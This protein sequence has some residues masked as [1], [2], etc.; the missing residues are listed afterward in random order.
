[1]IS[2]I[3]AAYSP[4]AICMSTPPKNQTDTLFAKPMGEITP[5]S[6]DDSVASVFPDMIKRSV[7]GYSAILSMIGDI[8]ERYAQDNSH[9][10]DLGCSLGAATLAM[11]HGIKAEGCQIV[12]VDNSTAMIERCEN[13]IAQDP[14]D[15]P[16]ELI[17]E[18]IQQ[19]HIR[20]AS[21][22]VLNFTLQFIEPEA[23]QAL[24]QSVYD[25][26]LPG[27][28]LLLSEKIH[29]DNAPHQNLMTTLYHNFKQTNGYSALEIAQKR[30]ALENVLRSDSLE[31]H[32]TRLTDCGFSSADVW[33]QC[34]SF[35]SLIAIK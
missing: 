28:I 30:T 31:T 10:Y 2:D 14:A 8:S 13:I 22:V 26:L 5:F 27:G 12:S 20:N 23:R 19:T 6:F 7:P 15:I 24:L 18:D 21:I 35:C 16:V 29:F 34:F 32:R 11:R 4:V 33:F 25:G 17:C 1:M 3:I 9:C